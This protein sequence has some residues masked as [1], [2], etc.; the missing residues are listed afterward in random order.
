MAI[1]GLSQWGGSH[2][3]EG[4]DR[5]PTHLLFLGLFDWRYV[6]HVEDIFAR[7]EI[8]GSLTASNLEL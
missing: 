5:M 2:E 1:R 7:L 3:C 8:Y 4:D 6:V